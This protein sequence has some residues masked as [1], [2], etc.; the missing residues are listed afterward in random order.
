[1]YILSVCARYT[2]NSFREHTMSKYGCF[3]VSWLDFFNPIWMQWLCFQKK[4]FLSGK[5]VKLH[6]PLARS[7]MNFSPYKDQKKWCVLWLIDWANNQRASGFSQAWPSFSQNHPEVKTLC[8]ALREEQVV[9]VFLVVLLYVC[10][11]LRCVFSLY[12]MK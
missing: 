10:F 7:A 8:R 1:M 5:V 12:W 6:Y 3:V 11:T 9:K 2:T 4:K